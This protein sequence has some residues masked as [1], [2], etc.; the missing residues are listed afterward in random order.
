MQL[1][2]IGNHLFGAS[3]LKGWGANWKQ[4]QNVHHLKLT[5]RCM[6]FL[7]CWA[8]TEGSSRGSHALLSHSVNI[9]LER[10]ASR[11]SEQVSLSEDALKALEALKQVCMMAPILAFAD[12]TK[13][14][15]LET[16]VSKERLGVCYHRIRQMGDTTLLPM[17]AGPLCL[18][19]RSTTQLS[20]NS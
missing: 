12:Y 19:R 1:F 7:G 20:S 6:P 5:L 3:S 14:F 13:L 15:L 16:D 10:D 9:W 11:K 17:A 4:L 18:M 8:T 2:H